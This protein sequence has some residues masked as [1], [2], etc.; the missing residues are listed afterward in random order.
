[1]GFDQDIGADLLSLLKSAGTGKISSTKLVDAQRVRR[2]S[3]LGAL[4]ST[5]TTG[6]GRKMSSI[7]KNEAVIGGAIK[8]ADQEEKE[9]EELEDDFEQEEFRAGDDVVIIEG[10]NCG[11]FG[12][13]Q[14]STGGIF[15]IFDDAVKEDE[16]GN[17]GVDIHP[18]DG[19]EDEGYWI[20]PTS[21]VFKD[22]SKEKKIERKTEED[23]DLEEVD[24]FEFLPYIA[25]PGDAMDEALGEHLNT[26]EIDINVKRIIARSG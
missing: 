1:M 2:A 9:D 13:L 18:A 16:E 4:A 12:T 10:D 15:G 25:F 7:E 17:F 26:L 20:H 3:A 22:P 8:L 5:I 21:M 6:D 11:L 14:H 19:G 23:L 24:K